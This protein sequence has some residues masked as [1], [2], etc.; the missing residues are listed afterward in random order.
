MNT[1]YESDYAYNATPL[2]LSRLIYS[3][4]EQDANLTL[5]FVDLL[6]SIYARGLI[7]AQSQFAFLLSRG[8]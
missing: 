7:K 6:T 3:R 1:I 4:S 8:N 2:S 5:S